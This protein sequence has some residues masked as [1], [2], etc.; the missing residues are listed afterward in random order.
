MVSLHY[1]IGE[2]RFQGGNDS[3]NFNN[4]Y[5]TERTEKMPTMETN[6]CI[7]NHQK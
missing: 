6:I 3:V 7:T 2:V 4:Q 5:V 1:A